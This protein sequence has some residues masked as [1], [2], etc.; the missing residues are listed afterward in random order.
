[1]KS[2]FS[3]YMAYNLLELQTPLELRTEVSLVTFQIL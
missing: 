2:H 1:M 3:D